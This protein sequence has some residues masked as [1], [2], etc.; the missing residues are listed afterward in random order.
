MSSDT[1]VLPRAVPSS[2]AA[3]ASHSLQIVPEKLAEHTIELGE[4]MAQFVAP[5]G[6]ARAFYRTDTRN[7][8]SICKDLSCSLCNSWRARPVCWQNCLTPS[9]GCDCA[10]EFRRETR[11]TGLRVRRCSSVG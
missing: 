10:L 7:A 9:P 1:D 4:A 8:T 5:T 11:F 6:S 2:T 3:D